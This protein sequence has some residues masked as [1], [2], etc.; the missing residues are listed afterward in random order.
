MV[1]IRQTLA[2]STGL[3]ILCTVAPRADIRGKGSLTLMAQPLEFHEF[4]I[5]H[6]AGIARTVKMGITCLFKSIQ[7]DK[8]RN[9]A[10]LTET[11]FSCISVPIQFVL[12]YTVVA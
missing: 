10:V 5:G 3:H 8:T 4:Q 1:A 9:T 2:A 12:L 11:L 7:G 6:F